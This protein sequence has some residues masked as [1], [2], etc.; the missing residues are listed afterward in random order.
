MTGVT[1]MI[2]GGYAFEALGFCIIV[3]RQRREE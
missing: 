1:S 2:L 3:G